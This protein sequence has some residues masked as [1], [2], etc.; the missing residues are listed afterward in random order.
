MAT[1]ITDFGEII[2]VNSQGVRLKGEKLS[3]VFPG[4]RT[5]ITERCI[6]KR[7]E[8]IAD[9]IV[10]DY[11]GDIYCVVVL[12]GG[13]IFFSDLSREMAKNKSKKQIIYTTIKAKSYEGTKSTGNVKIEHDC[14]DVAGKDVLIVEDI[15]D[16]GITMDAL[17]KYLKEVKKAKSVRLCAILNKPSR[18]EKEVKIDY[19]GFQ[20]PDLFVVG[21]GLDYNQQYRCLPFVGVISKS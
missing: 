21:Y 15:I 17:I 14:G 12:Q 10:K 11:K 19:E 6:E 3:T 7:V 1:E 8:N 2:K 16:T 20:I 4:V 9:Q 5:L 13:M 18:R